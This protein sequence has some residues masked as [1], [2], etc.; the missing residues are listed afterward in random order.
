MS[1]GGQGDLVVF[2]L[3]LYCIKRAL[4]G[5]EGDSCGSRVARDCIRL[6][7][8]AKKP[9][10]VLIKRDQAIKPATLLKWRL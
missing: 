3:F 8:A 4:N 2:C 6:V 10:L 5:C 7:F 1:S 9:S